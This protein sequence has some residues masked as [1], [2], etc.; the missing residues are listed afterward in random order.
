MKTI[1]L[2]IIILCALVT[3]V[4]AQVLHPIGDNSLSMITMPGCT[5][6]EYE[7][8][9]CGKTLVEH[10]EDRTSLSGRMMMSW[11]T[12]AGDEGKTLTIPWSIRV[13][14]DCY[15]KYLPE[16]KLLN[17]VANKITKEWKEKAIN[18]RLIN[19]EKRRVQKLKDVQR[20]VEQL[21]KRIKELQK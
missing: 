3:G 10:R 2:T 18:E 9:I 1:A 8:A 21:Q 20:E 12:C 5:A 6:Y 7:C 4:Q 16:V 19:E 14:R 13:C 15:D 17:D 11:G